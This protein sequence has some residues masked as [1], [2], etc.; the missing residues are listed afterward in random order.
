[1]QAVAG[2]WWNAIWGRL[3]RRDVWLTRETR[4]KVVARAGDTETGRGLRWESDTEAEARAMVERLLAT[5]A[6]GA[7]NGSHVPTKAPPRDQPL[8][9][10]PHWRGLWT[11]PR[12]PRR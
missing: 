8:R 2:R 1:M 3:A 7:G 6:D 11:E 10:L 5:D 9:R 4:W 12:P